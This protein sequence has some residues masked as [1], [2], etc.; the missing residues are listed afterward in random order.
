MTARRFGFDLG[1]PCRV[2][3]SVLVCLLTTFCAQSAPTRWVKAGVDEATTARE[4]QACRHEAAGVLATQQGINADITA[5]LG[6]NWQRSNM[7]GLRTESLNRSAVS[8]ADQTVAN[9]MLAKG[10]SRAS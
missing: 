4:L 3:G 5:T 9:C 6:G 1:L 8:A 7:L 10:F 2:A